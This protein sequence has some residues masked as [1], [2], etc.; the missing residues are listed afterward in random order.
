MS[1]PPAYA[2]S[3]SNLLTICFEHL[4]QELLNDS[5]NAA[6]DLGSEV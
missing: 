5:I 3:N 6:P 2:E 4:G 1:K